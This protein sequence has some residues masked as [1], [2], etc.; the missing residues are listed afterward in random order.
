MDQ[1]PIEPP[2]ITAQ[3]PLSI[4]QGE[5][6][7]IAFNHVKVTDPDDTYPNGFTL[8]LYEGP[9]YTFNG[10]TVTPQPDFQGSLAVGV[11]VND[12]QNESNKFSLKIDVVKTQNIAPVI[13]GQIA[14]STNEDQPFSILLIHLKAS[15]EDDNY[16]NGFTVSIGNGP[17]YSSEENII[18]PAKN[19][20][21]I[22]S[23]PVRISDGKSESAPFA[24]QLNV[25]PINDPPVITGQ[26]P[27]SIEMNSILE[28]KLSD[29]IIEDPDNSNTKAFK[30]KI[31][32]GANYTHAG[33]SGYSG[34][35]DLP[36]V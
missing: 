6:I 32:N 9:N 1:T 16:P 13:N 11:S 19:F 12:G 17:N 29:L 22:L 7:T 15:D 10:T 20:S 26:I 2:Q 3:T 33:E 34:Q 5:S 27:L 31:S 24:F 8:K 35:Q 28:L 4:K 14:V 36:G 30:L 18:T 23:I 25:L 21:G